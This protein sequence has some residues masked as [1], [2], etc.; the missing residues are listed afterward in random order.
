MRRAFWASL[1]AFGCSLVAAFVLFPDRVPI[2]FG[3]DGQPNHWVSRIGAVALFTGIGAALAATLGGLAHWSDRIPLSVLNVPYKRWWLADPAREARLRALLMND[4]LGSAAAVM[5]L[6][7]TLVVFTIVLAR[8]DH[9][10][11]NPWGW[12]IVALWLVP[13]LGWLSWLF[14]VRYRPDDR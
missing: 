9:P 8:S 1:S 4:L 11:M 14:A 12:V 2:H 3:L 13:L 6:L 7:T 10:T 5:G